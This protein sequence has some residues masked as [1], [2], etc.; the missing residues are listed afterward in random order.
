ML[1]AGPSAAHGRGINEPPKIPLGTEAKA[2]IQ[3]MKNAGWL[4]DPGRCL[5]AYPNVCEA[6]FVNKCGVVV[7]AT[8]LDE[9]ITSMKPVAFIDNPPTGRPQYP[10]CIDGTD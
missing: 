10:P 1:A 4:A 6:D 8:F 9:K 2:T 5:K 7:R 3:R